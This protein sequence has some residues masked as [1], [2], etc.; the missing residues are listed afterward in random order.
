VP[1]GVANLAQTRHT[2][3]ARHRETWPNPVHCNETESLLPPLLGNLT[4]NR[5]VHKN[6]GFEPFSQR[7]W[8]PSP[9]RARLKPL[10]RP[11]CNNRFQPVPGL[12]AF[13]S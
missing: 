11:V 12:A 9:L 3:L 13:D 8:L 10:T 1:D 2:T 7:P 5:L 6:Y 4:H